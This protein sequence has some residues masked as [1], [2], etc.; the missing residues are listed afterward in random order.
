[1]DCEMPVLDGYGATQKIRE[2]LADQGSEATLPIVALT[3]HALPEDRRRCLAAGMDDYL[4]K[5]FS[6]GDLRT[7][8]AH[9][10][11]SSDVSI[12]TE[13]D[14]DGDEKD[15]AATIRLEALTA[16]GSLD[17]NQGDSLIRRL[18]DVYAESSAELVATI[19]SEFRSGS[20]ENVRKAAH[21]LKSSSGNVGAERLVSLCRDIEDA[22]RKDELADLADEVALVKRE[23][24]RALRE[25]RRLQA[26]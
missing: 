4:S 8:L 13:A 6:I 3:A 19:Q 17:P 5:P 26:T 15:S 24:D 21:A 25:L 12:D 1:M 18:I 9:W 7:M 22:A 23:H 20:N 10:L 2:W 11:I 16:I 14:D